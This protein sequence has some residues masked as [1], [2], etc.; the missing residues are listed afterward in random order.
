MGSIRKLQGSNLSS[1]FGKPDISCGVDSLRALPSFAIHLTSYVIRAVDKT[2]LGKWKF[3]PWLSRCDMFCC[4]SLS[5][6]DLILQKLRKF[7]WM[8]GRRRY[9]SVISPEKLKNVTRTVVQVAG[10]P[11]DFHPG[12]LHVSCSWFLGTVHV[13]FW[14]LVRILELRGFAA[15]SL[16]SR[17]KK[18]STPWCLPVNL[19]AL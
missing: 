17:I 6:L 1:N 9:R 13:S 7:L 18:R 14:G 5:A 15:G 12:T 4:L 10:R 11:A 3:S 8:V 16:L 2:S 19:T